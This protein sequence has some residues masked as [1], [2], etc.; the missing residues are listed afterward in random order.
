MGETET[1]KRKIIS[2]FSQLNVFNW[3]KLIITEPNLDKIQ[4]LMSEGFEIGLN[5]WIV[6]SIT[7]NFGPI[8]HFVTNIR[9]WID[10]NNDIRTNLIICQIYI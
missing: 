6:I 3:K 9:I 8:T 1:V 2:K 10:I 7:L 5:Q 4:N